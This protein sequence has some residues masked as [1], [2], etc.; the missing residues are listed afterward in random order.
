MTRIRNRRRSGRVRR[1]YRA[2]LQRLRLVISGL[3]EVFDLTP[4]WLRDAAIDV[5]YPVSMFDDEGVCPSLAGAGRWSSPA[6]LEAAQGW[7]AP[8]QPCPN[9]DF[10]IGIA[11]TRAAAQGR[12]WPDDRDRLVARWDVISAA[13]F[14]ALTTKSDPAWVRAWARR[15]R[16][17]RAGRRAE[18]CRE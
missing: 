9:R 13:F 3:L 17:G 10:L 2:G 15:Q 5:G 4:R 11:M 16:R 6:L 18:T 8:E 7:T 1:P 14:D 12:G